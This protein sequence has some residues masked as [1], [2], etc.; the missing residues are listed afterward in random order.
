MKF[1]KIVDN[2]IRFYYDNQQVNKSRLIGLPKV[3]NLL[4]VRGLFYRL[5]PSL[6]IG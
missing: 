2:V 3:L 5:N 1:Q 6:F 4:I